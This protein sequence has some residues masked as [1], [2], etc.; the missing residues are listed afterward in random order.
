MIYI[1]EIY[2]TT[3]KVVYNAYKKDQMGVEY[4]CA[5]DL[6]SEEAAI[7]IIR[8]KWK[9]NGRIKVIGTGILGQTE[10]FYD[11]EEVK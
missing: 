6:G 4:A 7:N 9:H 3:N 10:V 5:D 8:N 11:I 1:I 2:K